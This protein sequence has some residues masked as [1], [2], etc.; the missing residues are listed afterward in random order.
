MHLAGHTG[1][2][3]W[4]WLHIWNLFEIWTQKTYRPTYVA[5]L[6]VNLILGLEYQNIYS[7]GDRPDMKISS[8]DPPSVHQIGPDDVLM[9]S[10]GRCYTMS[11]PIAQI[12]LIVAEAIGQLWRFRVQIL[13]LL[14]K[15]FQTQVER[16]HLEEVTQPSFQPPSLI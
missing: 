16:L 9:T 8:S 14:K 10:V 6:W 12:N 3:W 7:K 15:P 4:F 11:F 1:G 13:N 2:I 5:S